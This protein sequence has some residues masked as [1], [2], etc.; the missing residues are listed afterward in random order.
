MLHY[1]GEYWLIVAG[2]SK[3]FLI[4]F[5]GLPLPTNCPCQAPHGPNVDLTFANPII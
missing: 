4:V 1:Y 3:G 2:V 5:G